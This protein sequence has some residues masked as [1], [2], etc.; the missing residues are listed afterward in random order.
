[1]SKRILILGDSHHPDADFDVLEQAR[2]FAKQHKITQVV[3]TGDMLDQKAWSRFPKGPDDDSPQLEWEKAVKSCLEMAKMF[4]NMIILNSNHDRRYIKKAA[5]AGLPKAMIR[6]LD[7]LIPVK[8]WKWHLGP[9]PLVID[10]TAFMHGDE[11]QGSVEVKATKL[12]MN[13]V[14][15]HTH[16]AELK[17]V[18]TF[19][20]RLFALDVGCTVDVNGRS[21]DYAASSLTKVW[22]GFGYIENG[23]PHLIPKKVR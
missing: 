10:N 11:L 5:E 23:V 20:K 15:G 16:K 13:V 8:G 7:E 12:G 3:S 2:Q 14:Q 19:D 6:T 18:C 17:Y 21:F 1:M 9:N 4:P 22:V